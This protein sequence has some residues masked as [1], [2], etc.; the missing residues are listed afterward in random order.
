MNEEL[1]TMGL[2]SKSKKKKTFRYNA[3]YKSMEGKWRFYSSA[4]LPNK[5]LDG[6]RKEAIR[7]L[8][9]WPRKTKVVVADEAGRTLGE[10]TTDNRGYPMW[11]AKGKVYNLSSNTGKISTHTLIRRA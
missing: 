1:M 10:I 5:D 11:E 4:V 6:A 8:S 2:V 7:E 9:T 3:Y